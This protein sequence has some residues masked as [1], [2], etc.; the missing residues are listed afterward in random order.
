MVLKKKR[1]RKRCVSCSKLTDANDIRDCPQCHNEC[2][3]DCVWGYDAIPNEYGK[4]E[5]NSCCRRCEQM[6]VE[7][8]YYDK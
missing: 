6:N 5:G 8:W 7:K 3:S 4:K 2:C 1:K